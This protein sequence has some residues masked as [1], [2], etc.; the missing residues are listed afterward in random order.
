MW[1]TFLNDFNAIALIF[2]SDFLAL[3]LLYDKIRLLFDICCP[4]KDFGL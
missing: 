4:A 3:K 2:Q 1:P